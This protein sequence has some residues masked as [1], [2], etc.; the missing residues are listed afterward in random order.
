MTDSRWKCR[1]CG[2]HDVQISL[3]TWYTETREGELEI[4]DTDTEAEV[5]WWYCT[6]CEASALGDP[7]EVEDE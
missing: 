2:S 6:A 4:V 5:L 3:P 7:N 1:E